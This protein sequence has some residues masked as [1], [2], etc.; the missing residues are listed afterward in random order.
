M[1]C[2]CAECHY[3]ECHYAECHYAECHYA[4]CH[5]AECRYDECHYG[6][7]RYVDCRSAPFLLKSLKFPSSLVSLTLLVGA[8]TFRQLT[9]FSNHK[10]TIFSRGHWVKECEPVQVSLILDSLNVRVR[11]G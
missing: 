10:K 5:Y 4:E 9:T 7:C 1:L 2:Y 3:A 6:E 8:R 11:L